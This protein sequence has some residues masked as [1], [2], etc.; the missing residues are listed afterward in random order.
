M[1]QNRATLGFLPLEALIEYQ[2][3]GGL[4]GAKTEDNELAGYLL[5]S[6]HQTYFRIVHLC[7]SERHRGKRVARR[8][9][10]ELRNSAT[11][12]RLI[13]LHCRRDYAANGMW[14]ILGF[15][16]LEEKPG[17][18]S[19]GHLLTH[20]SLTLAQDRQLQ[21]FQALTLDDHLDAVVDAQVFFDFYEPA[22][23]KALPSK[24]LLS[25]FLIDTL[26]L[27][28]TDE[29]L[30]EIDRNPNR[31]KR[32]QSR[33][34]AYAFRQIT[35]EP[36]LA[37]HFEST[38]QT[39]LPHNTP[40]QISDIRH[41]AKTAASDSNTFVTRD[42]TLL[43]HADEIRDLLNVTV[44]SPTQLIITAHE[45]SEKNKNESNRI[46]GTQIWW[47]YLTSSDLSKFPTTSFVEPSD[48]HRPFIDKLNTFLA[49]PHSFECTALQM[50]G[51]IVALR[52]LDTRE[53]DCMRVPFVSVARLRDR[54]LL[55]RFVI[56][57]TL[58]M[59][60]AKRR[61]IVLFDTSG[62]VPRMAPALL[63]TGFTKDSSAYV[64]YTVPHSMTR[65][66]IFAWLS[67]VT[68]NLHPAHRSL[69]D[70]ELQRRCSP[71]SIPG[72]SQ[73]YMLPIRPGYAMSLF[74]INQA[75]EDLFGGK[76]N[77][78]L[79]WENVYY[80]SATH[81]HLLR[82]PGRI[83]WYVS[84]PRKSVVAISHLD[85]VLVD[86]P[87]SLFRTFEKFGILDWKELYNMCGGDVTKKL[88]A[89]R[90]SHTFLFL[91]QVRLN[92]LNRIY[93]EHGRRPVLQSPSRIS[94]QICETIM[95]RGFEVQQ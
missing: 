61:R 63:D 65:Q 1:K 13:K 58:A 10:C 41:L 81:T 46:S 5:Y 88:M 94:P 91:N 48:R 38:L 92:E 72:A 84:A 2:E 82:A 7:V 36:T 45:L 28:T 31:S 40:S 34:R 4:L 77:V 59:A 33:Q 85:S 15:V 32:E 56:A 54:G 30:V 51:K 19:A 75:R 73:V 53:D 44:L 37:N 52:V 74:D 23:S 47:R 20:W 66:E 83:L 29:L 50:A 12:Q 17:R 11:T 76:T 60:V 57:D 79:R 27:W 43:G 22:S 86:T 78:L 9:L 21:L 87:K 69:D 93:G 6:K 68:P 35:H 71:L 62:I 64:R 70:V 18:S 49:Q 14:P 3:R 80:R 95:E 67:A 26:N 89:M 16:P 90:F 25:D 42:S 8:L 55:D 24:A 39:I